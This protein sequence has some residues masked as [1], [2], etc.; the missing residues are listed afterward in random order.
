ML[1][2]QVSQWYELVI[3][4][5]SMEVSTLAI[6]IMYRT[7]SSVSKLDMYNLMFTVYLLPLYRCMEW[8]WP[9]S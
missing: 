4:T 9:I 3:F 1:F 5:A 7:A 8:Q 6:Y 2:V